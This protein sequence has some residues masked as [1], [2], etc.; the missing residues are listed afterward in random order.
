LLKSLFILSSFANIVGALVL[1]AL[2]AT[3]VIVDHERAVPVVAIVI[4]AVMLAQGSFSFGYALEWWAG[5]RGAASW[6]LLAN[7]ML[8]ACVGVATIGY[9]IYYV[10]RA[11]NGGVE[12]GPFFSGAIILANALIALALLY[13]AGVLTPTSRARG[14]T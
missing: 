7:Q 2:I 13:S 5:W 14:G 12:P 11:A 4:A 9:A 6:T 8:C 3:G 1:F 10:P